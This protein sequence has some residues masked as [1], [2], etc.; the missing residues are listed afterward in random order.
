LLRG[1]QGCHA[2]TLTS[3][4]LDDHVQGSELYAVFG[5]CGNGTVDAGTG[6]ECDGTATRPT[7]AIVRTEISGESFVDPFY[8]I[9]TV[10]Q[11]GP[12]DL[13]AHRQRSQQL[14]RAELRDG[15][16]AQSRSAL[17]RFGNAAR[18]SERHDG[19]SLCHRLVRSGSMSMRPRSIL[20]DGFSI[21]RAR[22]ERLD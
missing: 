18:R 13:E 5:P 10:P 8:Q 7:G 20:I 22:R 16:R 14:L 21:L 1:R 4:P 19:R 12:G 11:S 3:A 17:L 6:E 9:L 15:A 2:V